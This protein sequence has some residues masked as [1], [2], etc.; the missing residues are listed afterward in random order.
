MILVDTSVIVAWLDKA[1]PHHNEC[2]R[3]ILSC[4]A[5]DQLAASSITYAEL[6]AGRRTR[7]A[8]DEDLKFFARLELNFAAAWRAGM[9]Y[10]QH[11]PGKTKGMVLPDFFIRA[12]AAVLNLPHLTNDR[13]RLTAWPDVEFIFPT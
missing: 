5:Q 1:H 10:R 8:V 6:A 13:R 12:Q 11:Y 3:S 2:L 4:A 7:E 9:A